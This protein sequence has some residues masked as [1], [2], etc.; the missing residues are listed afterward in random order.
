M[1]GAQYFKEFI[2]IRLRNTLPPPGWLLGREDPGARILSFFEKMFSEKGRE[3][4]WDNAEIH[5]C[6]FPQVPYDGENGRYLKKMSNILSRQLPPLL[7]EYETASGDAFLFRMLPMGT[8]QLRLFQQT[9]QEQSHISVLHEIE[10]FRL[11]Y[12]A[13]FVTP[14]SPHTK[15]EEAGM[16]AWE[17]L[18]HLERFAALAKARLEAETAN[19]DPMPNWASIFGQHSSSIVGELTEFYRTLKQ[20]LH[21]ADAPLLEG[22]KQDF[23][24]IAPHLDRFETASAYYLLISAFSN[25]ILREGG[26]EARMD[27]LRLYRD[28][29]ERG[30]F[31]N[32]HWIVPNTFISVAQFLCAS[33]D[34]EE[35]RSFVEN[36]RKYLL[37]EISESVS[38]FCEGLLLFQQ[39]RYREARTVFEAT[40]KSRLPEINLRGRAYRCKCNYELY[41]NLET[42]QLNQ[43]HSSLDGT[44]RYMSETEI[45]K[46]QADA[47]RRFYKGL[48]QLLRVRNALGRQERG[49]EIQK[50][51]KLLAS[52]L[53]TAAFQGWL[54]KKELELANSE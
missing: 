18:Y 31:S 44:D 24:Q 41:D 50:F 6:V 34:P 8:Q 3:A 54:L 45:G 25:R 40:E 36:H 4:Q 20:L 9:I 1:I 29:I 48:K 13:Y 53:Q 21:E 11:A 27:L 37:P 23:F 51:Q 19:L 46:S 12:Y 52:Q 22:A 10:R 30:I 32:G 28:G 17:C 47:Y 38:T 5:A 15:Q 42:W 33:G 26:M 43:F 49:R 2:R 39:A 35:A 7:K 16:L 14:M